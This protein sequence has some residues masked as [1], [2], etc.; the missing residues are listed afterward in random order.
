M[1]LGLHPDELFFFPFLTLTLEKPHLELLVH[2][3]LSLTLVTS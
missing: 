2:I 3:I 1:N